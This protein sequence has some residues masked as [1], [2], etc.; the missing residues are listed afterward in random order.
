M[1]ACTSPG[2]QSP[3]KHR[4]AI[5]ELSIT[6]DSKRLYYAQLNSTA[7]ENDRKLEMIVKVGADLWASSS[8]FAIC[9]LYDAAWLLVGLLRL[10]A[11]LSM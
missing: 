4:L 5:A 7:I 3:E 8:L 1:Y 11:D 9:Y 2:V 10:P 6:A